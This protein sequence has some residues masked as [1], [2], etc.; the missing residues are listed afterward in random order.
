MKLALV[1]LG[2]WGGK[3]LRNMV[4]ML[5]ADNVVAVDQ[6]EP[7]V[8]WARDELSRVW[9]AQ[10]RW[11]RRWTCRTSTESSSPHQSPATPR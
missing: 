6:S 4:A 7:L 10:A 3:V 5:G 2:Y 9:S 1:G 11:R 8:E